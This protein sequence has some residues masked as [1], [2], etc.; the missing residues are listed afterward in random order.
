MAEAEKPGTPPAGDPPGTPPATPPAGD[1]PGQAPNG[2]EEDASKLTAEQLREK[3]AAAEGKLTKAVDESKGLREKVKTLEAADEERKKADMTEVEKAKA[4]LDK[5]EKS[6]AALR[7][8]NLDLEIMGVAR[9]LGF[10]NPAFGVK[11]IDR[12]ALTL[13]DDG[14]PSNAKELL[15][16][17]LK[18]SPELKG[19]AGN[20]RLPVTNGQGNPTGNGHAD[21]AKVEKAVGHFPWLKTRV[22][23]KN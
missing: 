22:P 12:E 1:P 8:K 11:L 6:V 3:L 2:T 14:S 10:K 18:D 4:E 15:E 13:S 5:S 16:K 19:N 23:S 20:G 7:A 21:A 17:I 9:D